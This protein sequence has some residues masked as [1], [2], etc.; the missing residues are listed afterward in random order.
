M[1]LDFG[2][3]GDKKYVYLVEAKAGKPTELLKA[4]A[5]S[6]GRRLKGVRFKRAELDGRLSELEF[7]GWLKL[8]VTLERPEPGLKDRLKRDYPNLLIVEQRMPEREQ[9]EAGGIDHTRVELNEAF[10]QYYLEVRSEE[11]PSD[12]QKAFGSLYQETDPLADVEELAK[13]ETPKQEALAPETAR[14]EA[15]REDALTEPH[16][17]VRA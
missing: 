13:G 1:Q 7:D 12:L 15:A 9:G 17:K 5:L 8:S 3:Q 10:A 14:Q 2:E 16:E 4:H 11:L 6:A